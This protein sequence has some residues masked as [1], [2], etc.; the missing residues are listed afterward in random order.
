MAWQHTA[1]FHIIVCSVVISSVILIIDAH[2]VMNR[3]N[4]RGALRTGKFIQH[5][6][7]ENAPFDY[8][9]HFPAGE[10]RAKPG[11]GRR[12]QE[13]AAGKIGWKPFTPLSPTFHW[14]AGVCG[15]LKGERHHMRGGKYYYNGKIVAKYTQGSVIDVELTIIAHHNGFIE[16]HICDVSKCQGEISEECFRKGHCR[17]LQRAWNPECESGNSYKCGPI[18]RQNPGR[19]YLPCS[20]LPVNQRGR[21]EYYQGRAILYKLPED[22]VCSHCVIQWFWSTANVC[23]PP[24]VIDYFDGPDAP[25]WGICKGQ[26]AAVGGVARLQRNCSKDR[27]PE[28]YLQCADVQ[29]VPRKEQ[30]EKEILKRSM[31]PMS[32]PILARNTPTPRAVAFQPPRLATIWKPLSE[33]GALRLREIH[34]I[35]LMCRGRRTMNLYESQRNVSLSGCYGLGI[36]PLIVGKVGNVSF[37]INNKLVFVDYSWPYVLYGRHIDPVFHWK[38]YLTGWPIQVVIRAGRDTDMVN[39]LLTE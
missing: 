32:L 8:H 21:W 16:L 20:K 37:F 39:I 26:G 35:M 31:I 29:I 19:W 6:I 9:M 15:D 5:G 18:D 24:G 22:L 36:E 28:E 38:R 14:R 25:N 17:Q 27:F 3:P 4:Q 34:E 33:K 2:G 13:R 30:K 7:D 11:S 1:V 10:K 23:N 12:S